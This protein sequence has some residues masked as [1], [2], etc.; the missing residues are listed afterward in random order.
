MVAA[1]AGIESIHSG[2]FRA[3]ESDLCPKNPQR[4][5]HFW[6]SSRLPFVAKER[7]M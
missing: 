7:Y 2:L 5:V 3:K 1:R 4:R 6:D